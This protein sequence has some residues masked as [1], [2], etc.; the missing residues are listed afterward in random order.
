MTVTLDNLTHMLA[1]G[2]PGTTEWIVILIVGLLIFGRRL[3]EVG[4][5]LGRSIVEFKRGVKGIGDEIDA[6]S[7]KESSSEQIT[8]ESIARSADVVED[9]AKADAE[10]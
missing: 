7:T 3:P 1:F 6:E 10:S 5:S 4:R 8:D 2:F 9:V